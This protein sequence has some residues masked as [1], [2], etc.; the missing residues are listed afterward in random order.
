MRRPWF[1][2][3]LNVSFFAI[4]LGQPSNDNCENAIFI[5][6]GPTAGCTAA[7]GAA[8]TLSGDNFDATPSTP[9]FQFADG[10]G[11]GP[12]FNGPSADVWYELAPAGNRLSISMEGGVEFPVLALFQ[13]EDCTSALPIAWSADTTGSGAVIL[14]ART[15]P[16]QTYLL[17]VGGGTLSDQGAF[18]LSITT[19]EDCSTCARRRGVLAADP[20]PVNG[21]YQAGQRVQFCYQITFW[22]P[23]LSLEWLHGVE[24]QFGPG[25]DRSTLETIAPDAC[26][27]PDGRWDWYDSWQGCNTGDSFGPGFAFDA[28]YG[29]LC[30][31]AGR[32]D[33]DP[34][35]NFGDGPC[36]SITAAAL[37]LEFCWTIQVSEDFSTIE[38]ANLNMEVSLLGDGYSGSWMPFSC[39]G[40]PATAFFATA[41]PEASL[42]P[43]IDI[44][45]APCSTDCDG[46]AAISG[47]ASGV[48]Q[49][50]I[51]D[52]GG[53]LIYDGLAQPV[54]D[55][56]YSLC[57]G[58]YHFEVSNLSGTIRQATL[59]EIEAG[60]APEAQAG[61]IPGCLPG[62]PIQLVAGI[63]ISG[64]NITYRWTGPNGFTSGMASPSVDDPGA[65]FLDVEVDGCHA[66][67]ATIQAENGVPEI[68]CE[69]FPDR[70][71]FS[72]ATTPG[73]TAYAVDV[74]SGQAGGWLSA[75]AFEVSGLA[76][77]EEAS[78]ELTKHGTGLCPTSI[79]EATCRAL[80]CP[81]PMVTPDTTICR[82]QSVRLW[83]NVPPN[84]TAVWSPADGLSC[85]NC[86]AP[87]AS[88]ATNTTYQVNIT[89]PDGCTAT[90]EVAV[91]VSSLPESILPNTSIPYCLGASWEL[92]LPE[93]NEYLW[94]SP[95]GSI[96][97]GN[98]LT[99]PL[100]TELLTGRHTVR[101]TLPSGC[102]FYDY[103]YLY[104]KN[105]VGGSDIQIGLTPSARPVDNGNGQTARA[106]PN[107]A[108]HLLHVEMASPGFKTLC[109]F[110][111]DGQRVGEWATEEHFLEIPTG[112]FPPGAYWL[113]VRSAL[114]RERLKVVVM[115]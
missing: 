78:I 5:P 106:Y 92:C 70:I 76:P 87:L 47:G 69:A 25:W 54:P 94:F 82:G 36:S 2:L 99:F 32:L 37:P 107:P 77:G 51:T 35:N 8:A 95:V 112:Q 6:L 66:P 13:A 46:I 53:G 23:G 17:L 10:L 60:L 97:T 52:E 19:F 26:T 39:D 28:A 50:K 104:P 84:T 93:G 11:A 7:A 48:W 61:F 45:K 85:T 4:A 57:P 71:V 75:N 18:G 80:T 63:N 44:V 96:S 58:T 102:E 34:G 110:R 67:L 20:P 27:A 33:G 114:G 100:T 101:V 3:L 31:G 9:V 15:E 38:E 68:R 62:E 42:L 74:L 14:E 79:G 90:R 43:N 12:A 41:M 40:E 98:C 29:L 103:F 73:D 65:Y 88:P 86:I 56:L 1:T 59:I 55:T 113:E 115:R 89:Y 64:A 91:Y 24:I 49:Y 111:A 83:A 105:C 30:P 72:W 109:F 81:L 21:H 16:G 108:Q 22:D